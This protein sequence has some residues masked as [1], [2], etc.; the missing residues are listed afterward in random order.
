ML[1]D[2]GLKSYYTDIYQLAGDDETARMK[3]VEIVE[4]I[5]AESKYYMDFTKSA[6]LDL[7]NQL[8]SK[9]A[10]LARDARDA[11]GISR[12]M[13]ESDLEQRMTDV[14]NTLQ[15]PVSAPPQGT[16]P[17]GTPPQQGQQPQ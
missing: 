5:E 6:S 9:I 14:M 12:R 15:P 7:K 11:A 13:N 8:R 17:Q 10:G 16:P 1:M 2:L 3:L 4:R